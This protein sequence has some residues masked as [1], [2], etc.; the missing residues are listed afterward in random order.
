MENN[1]SI[2]LVTYNRAN[3]LEVLLKKIK[4]Y[5]WNY[6]NFVIVDNC[7]TDHT[8]ELLRQFSG[9]LQL[10]IL[11][12]N[13]NIGHGAGLALAL[14]LLLTNPIHP[15]Y[16]VFLEDDSIPS[17]SLVEILVRQ[18]DQS[19]YDLL[20][21]LGSINKVGKRHVVKPLD[22]SIQ[23]VDFVV[24]DGAILSFKVVKNIGIPEEDWFM[25]VDD[26]EYCFRI[27]KAGFRIGVVE[28]DFHEVLHLGD[29]SGFTKSSLWRGYY[30]ERNYVL[31]VKKHFTL[32]TFADFIF[33]FT[34]RVL[35]CIP[36]PDRSLRIGLKFMGLWHGLLNKK[37]MTLDP[38][39]IRFIS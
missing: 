35:A 38:I 26:Y 6:L 22:K 18:I 32:I 3:E 7:S 2:I 36:A 30:T 1:V 12:A 5:N 29:G 37:G 33:F 25:M 28:N 9:I 4:V 21:P 16:V 17:K 31:F 19:P 24:F 13:S 8:P 20:A 27:K 23:E 34:K 39:T 14:E 11:R 15:E 10:D